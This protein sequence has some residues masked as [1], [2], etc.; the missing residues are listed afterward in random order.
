MS[1]TYKGSCFCG[2]VEIDRHRRT[3]RG[4]FLSLLVVP[5]LVGRAGQRV[6][7]LEARGG[8]GHQG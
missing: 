1:H 3:G 6:Q 2:A 4:G 7:P 5:Q 8:E